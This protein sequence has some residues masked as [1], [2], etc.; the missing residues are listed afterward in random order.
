MH[1]NRLVQPARPAGAVTAGCRVGV[2]WHVRPAFDRLQR[3]NPFTERSPLLTA[4]G[5]ISRHRRSPG[6]ME[7]RRVRLGHDPLHVPRPSTI[8]WQLAPVRDR[9]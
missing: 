4:F 3:L 8:S 5:V 1:D 9:T 7:H 6:N 2:A